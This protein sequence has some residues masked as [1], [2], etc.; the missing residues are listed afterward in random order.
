MQD[1]YEF[2]VLEF[3]KVSWCFSVSI[4]NYLAK[5]IETYKNLHTNLLTKLEK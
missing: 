1:F 4:N 2:G 5:K 3:L